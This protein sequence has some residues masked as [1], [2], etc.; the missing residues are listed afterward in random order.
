MLAIRDSQDGVLNIYGAGTYVGDVDLPEY[1][2]G[3]NFG[4]SNP[5]IELD[6]GKVVFGCECWWGPEEHLREK[7]ADYQFMEVDIDK[8]R[9]KVEE[10]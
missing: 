10:D 6:N 8:D 2:G 1:A 9:I 5:K 3:F 7:Y 4:Q